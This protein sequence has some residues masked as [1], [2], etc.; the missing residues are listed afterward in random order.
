MISTACYRGY[1]CKYEFT[2]D[3]LYLIEMEVRTADNQYPVIQGVSARVMY[4]DIAQYDGLRI[5]CN[6]SGGVILVRDQLKRCVVVCNP[7]CFRTVI[8]IVMSNG[9]VEALID[10]SG[11][12]HDIRRRMDAITDSSDRWSIRKEI[13]WSFA[14]GYEERPLVFSA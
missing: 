11:A 5:S 12:M 9:Q 8:E 10:H 6:L 2:D 14:P 1:V 4:D 3:R 13:E 7:S